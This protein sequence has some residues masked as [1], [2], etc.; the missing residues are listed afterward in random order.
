MS[1][2]DVE[3][4]LKNMVTI[5]G[6]N[7]LGIKA[8]DVGTHS[9]RSSGAMWMYLNGVRTYT[10]MLQGR[11]SSDAFLTYIRRQ[12]KEF[13]SNVSTQMIQHK[14]FYK[15]TMDEE[16][17]DEDHT[18]PGD[19]NNFANAGS[20]TGAPFLAPSFHLWE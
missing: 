10:I 7:E 6:E 4:T 5:I 19:R 17:D 15:V 9:N 13:S 12:V 18:I 20:N 16:Q 8:E 2:K 3:S 14:T 1:G 11:W